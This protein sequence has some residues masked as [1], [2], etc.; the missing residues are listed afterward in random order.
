[1]LFDFL[2][3]NFFSSSLFDFVV[4]LDFI[5]VIFYFH[6]KCPENNNYSQDNLES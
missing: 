5:P 2:F 1:M 6:Y 4:C 3:L